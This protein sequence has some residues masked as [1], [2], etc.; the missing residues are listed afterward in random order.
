MRTIVGIFILAQITIA[1][2]IYSDAALRSGSSIA[3]P[4][5][6]AATIA[7]GLKRG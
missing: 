4:D 6:A 5:A 1:G 3:A 7:H 2:E